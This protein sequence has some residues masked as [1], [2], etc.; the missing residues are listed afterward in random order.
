MSHSLSY[1]CIY[2]PKAPAWECAKGHKSSWESFLQVSHEKNPPTFHYTGWL[3]GILIMAY[4]N[5]YITGSYNPL[6]NPTNQGFFHCQVSSGGLK[7]PPK[8]LLSNPTSIGI[9]ILKK[10]QRKEGDLLL[11]NSSY[12]HFSGKQKR[13]HIADSCSAFLIHTYPRDVSNVGHSDNS[14]SLVQ[15]GKSKYPWNKQKT[16][17]PRTWT[18]VPRKRG[19]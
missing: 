1:P 6:Y 17:L 4:Y 2:A 9:M 18:N 7:F 13:P 14:T 12:G 5:P 15:R 11:Y 3:I 8:F 10:H 16:W 19:H